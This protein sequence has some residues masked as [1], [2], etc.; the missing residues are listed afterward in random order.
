MVRLISCLVW[1]GL[2]AALP[3]PAIAQ[4]VTAPP[5]TRAEVLQRAREDKRQSA[6][7][8]EPNALER[9][10][11][12]AEVRLTRVLAAPDGFYPKIGSLTTGSGFAFG[13]G[14]RNRQLF[15]REGAIGAWAAGSL[16]N[17]WAVEGRFD[18][19]DLAGG[20][21]S[22]GTYARRNNY[23]Q[24]DFFGIGPDSLR[25]DHSS[26]RFRDTMVG[27]R[28]GVKAAP[29]ATFGGGLEYARPDRGQGPEQIPPD[30]RHAVRRHVC[31]R[32][33]GRRDH[34]RSHE[35]VSRHRLPGTQK[36]PA[37]RLVSPR[38]QP[39]QRTIRSVHVQPFRRG[40]ASVRE[41][42]RR[43][44]GARRPA[45][46]LD[47]RPGPWG[48]RAVLSTCRRSAGTIRCAGFAITGSA[49]RTRF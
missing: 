21:L 19:P 44:P 45:V 32:I 18:I 34:L 15:N 14:Y 16:K 6:T 33:V 40:S 23:P 27:S 46:C 8:Y 36:R 47:I 42:P 26:F 41:H 22:F 7:P 37:G 43:T 30:D 29:I 9:A 38:C 28:V 2:L 13:A 35:R 4:T 3:A 49:D 48:P 12:L 25:S 1:V 11:R 31:A 20:R 5:E 10:M 39:L 17:Y 24:E